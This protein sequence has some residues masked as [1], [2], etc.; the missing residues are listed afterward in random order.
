MKRLSSS[1][2]FMADVDGG[3]SSGTRGARIM[4]GCDAVFTR[5]FASGKESS[6][7]S[8]IDDSDVF[9]PEGCDA[10]MRTS[11]DG[12]VRKSIGSC[13]FVGPVFN[14]FAGRSPS[15][16]SST[17]DIFLLVDDDGRVDDAHDTPLC[18]RKPLGTERGSAAKFVVRT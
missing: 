4:R 16:I 9:G 10:A 13:E 5:S 11:G 7:D 15:S 14:L 1:L 6:D 18:I 17:S 8:E 2:G 12:G 3:L